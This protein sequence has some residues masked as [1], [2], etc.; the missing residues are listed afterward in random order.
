MLFIVSITPETCES[1]DSKT[2][3]EQASPSINAISPFFGLSITI[4]ITVTTA[5]TQTESI[6]I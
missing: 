6:F 3:T 4:M 1:T 5:S 2:S